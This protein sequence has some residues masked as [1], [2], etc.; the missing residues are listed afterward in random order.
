MIGTLGEEDG[1]T[2]VTFES[3]SSSLEI[4]TFFEYAFTGTPSGDTMAGST[5]R[6]APPLKFVKK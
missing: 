1:Q 4:T 3:N 6:F 5:R 2:V